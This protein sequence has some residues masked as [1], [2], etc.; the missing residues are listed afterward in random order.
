MSKLI[1]AARNP[2][3]QRRLRSIDRRGSPRVRCGA[4]LQSCQFTQHLFL[5]TLRLPVQPLLC[6]LAQHQRRRLLSPHDLL[7]DG[8][9]RGTRALSRTEQRVR[10]RAGYAPA[11]DEAS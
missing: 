3:P 8:R 1:H 4:Q 5:V 9:A 11:S 10:E 7:L 2:A 6:A